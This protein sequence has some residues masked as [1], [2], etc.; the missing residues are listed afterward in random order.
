MTPID[1]SQGSPAFLTGCARTPWSPRWSPSS[2]CSEIRHS[3]ERDGQQ[4]GLG[5]RFSKGK[6]SSRV[7]SLQSSRPCLQP[8]VRPFSS[9]QTWRQFRCQAAYET[10][11]ESGLEMIAGRSHQSG[12]SREKEESH[13]PG[14]RWEQKSRS[15]TGEAGRGRCRL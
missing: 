7:I 15:S 9:I 13:Q 12:P 1:D 11:Q 10:A 14:L 2:H 6:P 5:K 8:Y 4:E 3:C